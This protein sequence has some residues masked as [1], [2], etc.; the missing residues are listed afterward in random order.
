VNFVTNLA[1]KS[2]IPDPKENV[3]RVLK[4]N[5]NGS[6]EPKAPTAQPYRTTVVVPGTTK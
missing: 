1:L 4:K 2:F 6:I 3:K 5:E